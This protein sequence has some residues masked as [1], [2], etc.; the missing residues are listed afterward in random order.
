MPTGNCA[1]G[2]KRGRSVYTSDRCARKRNSLPSTSSQ[3]TPSYPIPTQEPPISSPLPPSVCELQWK[4]PKKKTRVDEAAKA[5]LNAD[6][7]AR[8]LEK[9]REQWLV[10]QEKERTRQRDVELQ[11]QAR[12]LSLMEEWERERRRQRDVELQLQARLL[13]LM[14]HIQ[15]ILK[16]YLEI[17]E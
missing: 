2:T 1:I 10:E 16:Q 8:E 11:L 4:P 15:A 5:F 14:E 6:K 13:S 17:G 12:L 9:E 3:P 7:K